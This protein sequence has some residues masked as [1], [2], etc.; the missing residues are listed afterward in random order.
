MIILELKGII[1]IY[2][3]F[4]FCDTTIEAKGPKI[5]S[6]FIS[7]ETLWIFLNKDFHSK[8]EKT[9]QDKSLIQTSEMFYYNKEERVDMMQI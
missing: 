3:F 1:W 8:K 5:L 6:D 7:N 9:K 2:D 4:F